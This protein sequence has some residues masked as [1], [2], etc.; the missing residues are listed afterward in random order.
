MKINDFT[1]KPLAYPN[2]PPEAVS[3][4]LPGSFVC[5]PDLPELV[6]SCDR[7][8]LPQASSMRVGEGWSDDCNGQAKINRKM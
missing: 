2:V 4:L 6:V 7:V 5:L 1:T 3:T 8:T